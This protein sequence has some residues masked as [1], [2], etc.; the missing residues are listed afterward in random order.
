MSKII[1]EADDNRKGI[2]DKIFVTN[3]QVVQ[4]GDKIANIIT[5]NKVYEIK[6]PITG[7]VLNIIVYENK[8]INSGD[9]LLDLLPFE[10]TLNEQH[11]HFEQPY[12]TVS[13]NGSGKYNMQNRPPIDVKKSE[14]EIFREE[15]IETLLARE[16]AGENL[17]DDFDDSIEIDLPE[18]NIEQDSTPF[19]SQDNNSKTFP[20][21]DKVENI[22]ENIPSEE[23]IETLQ[24][25]LGD[26]KED[27]AIVKDDLTTITIEEEIIEDLEN[28]ERDL[29][30]KAEMAEKKQVDDKISEPLIYHH[31][32][33]VKKECKPESNTKEELKSNFASI[34]NNADDSKMQPIIN[35]EK[36]KLVD[37]ES[38]GHHGEHSTVHSSAPTYL[39][40][41][42]AED[43][44]SREHAAFSGHKTK[45]NTQSLQVDKVKLNQEAIIRA[46]EIMES[47]KNIAHSFIDV[48]VDVSELVSL[49][50]I[51]R[52]AYSQNDIK[53][54]LLPF[55]A[56][57]VYDGLKKFPILNASFISQEKAILLKWFYNIAFSVDS[58]TAVKMPVLYN[59]KNVSIKEIASK[60]TKLIGKSIN[61]ELKE[62]DYQD[63]SFSIVN[64]GEYGIT[65][66]TFTIPD[67]NV[68]G[69][70]MGII[71]KKPVVVEKNDIAIRDI[72]VITLGYNE[73]VI[74]ITEASKF[75]HYVAYLLSNPG[76]L[77]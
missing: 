39:K 35:L 38:K 25:D 5:Q 49:L 10:P 57:A 28:L 2:V 20:F 77:L 37:D 36:D 23:N 4:K 14:T 74:D 68:A 71:F 47:K 55:Y 24:K 75:V 29:A 63:A 73:A 67:D 70:A 30:F 12:N 41:H 34:Q 3:K 27:L 53:L 62:K 15:L 33:D 65:R 22:L 69:I 50:S 58:D 26:L 72:M 31:P 17:Q 60:V 51:M 9:V 18:E 13:F 48:E 21:K 1:F 59:L 52:E 45:E 46:K 19:F 54:T 6:A 40:K 7:E 56:K 64:Y 42:K 76:L 8:V 11:N 16:V 44:T 66:G 32:F 43:V 61:N